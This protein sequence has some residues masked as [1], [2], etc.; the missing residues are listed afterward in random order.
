MRAKFPYK[1]KKKRLGCGSGSGHGKTSTKGNK[2][3][4]ARSGYSRRFGFEGGQNPLYRKIPKRGFNNADFKRQYAIVNVDRLEALEVSEI[5]PEILKKRG[6]IHD[7]EDGVRVLGDG[8]LSKALTVK[9]HYFTKS[10]REKI[11]GAGG[12]VIL[13]DSVCKKVSK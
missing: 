5:D 9:A 4:K 8:K 12:K 3:Q 6:L 11:E 13:M 2:G 10:A 7:V 1:K